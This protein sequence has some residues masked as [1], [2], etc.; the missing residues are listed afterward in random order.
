MFRIRLSDASAIPNTS[1]SAKIFRPIIYLALAQDESP[2]H[3]G[4]QFILRTTGSHRDLVANFHAAV[5]EVNPEIGIQFRVLT[6]RI[7]GPLLRD[8]LMATLSGAFGLLAGLLATLGLYG[9]ISY[10][11]RSDAMKLVRAWAVGADRG[12][13]IGLEMCEARFL[14][15]IGLIAGT[16]SALWT[17][18]AASTLLFGLKPYDPATLVT[19]CA[20]LAGVGV[21][22]SY[23]P[24]R[25]ASRPDPMHALREEYGF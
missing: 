6:Q 23:L 1:R 3:S 12:G 20:V 8:R 18:R 21:V 13:V 15:M 24:L 19:A 11:W 16:A 5:A 14:L 4:A 7:K 25:S 17:A 22:A 10:M 9:V 2:S